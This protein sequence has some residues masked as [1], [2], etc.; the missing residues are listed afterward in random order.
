MN[1]V[2]LKYSKIVSQEVVVFVV[3]PGDVPFFC[4]ACPQSMQRIINI[5][6]FHHGAVFVDHGTRPMQP[7]FLK[8]AQLDELRAQ[9]DTESVFL[10]SIVGFPLVK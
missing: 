10:P 8:V 6:F 3:L 5:I 7:I 1:V 9:N 2:R 4:C